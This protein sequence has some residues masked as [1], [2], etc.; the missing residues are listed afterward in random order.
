MGELYRRCT[1]RTKEAY[2]HDVSGRLIP[3]I[4]L[5]WAQLHQ[6]TSS[7]PVLTHCYRAV[8]VVSGKE[9]APMLHQIL[10]EPET[11][12]PCSRIKPA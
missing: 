3:A 2:Y 1:K 11:G 5:E 4:P 10:D 6:L 7:L 9:K 8:F 12:L